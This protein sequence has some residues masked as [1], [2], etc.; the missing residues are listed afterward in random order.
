MLAEEANFLSVAVEGAGITRLRLWVTRR[1]SLPSH[2]KQPFKAALP[3]WE[4][5]I[6]EI[7]AMAGARIN[8]EQQRAMHTVATVV[9]DAV[10]PFE[11]AV[12]TEVF[13]VERPELGVPWYRF[14]VCGVEARPVRTS[15]GLLVTPLYALSHLTEADTVIVPGPRPGIGPIPS[16]LLEALRD[17][18]QRGARLLS[19]CTGAFLLAAAGLLDGRRATTHWLWAAELATRYPKVQ[20]DP[21]VLYID[22]GQILTSAGA[23]ASIDLSLHVVRQDYGAAIAAAV[24]RRMVV[25]PHR[26]GGQAQYIETPLP[27]LDEDDPFGATLTWLL[28]H[29]QEDLS[30]EQ[31]AARAVM[32]PRTFARRFRATLGTT[33]YQWLLQQR[34]I[35]AQRL[36]E[37]TAESVEYIAVCCGFRSA[38]TFRL[39]FEH[40][41]H[42]SPQTYRRAF[43]QEQVGAIVAT[44][45]EKS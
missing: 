10:N 29:L 3:E 18:Y 20:V 26:E 39:H 45:P 14:L 5:C 24:A 27:T 38:A 42:L 1:P 35:L 41:L 13:G 2:E 19:F 16:A 4:R 28:G 33:P 37:T 12:A 32:S 17:A 23:A 44:G 9:Y 25:S 34:I 36:L 30:V 21:Q 15:V 43:H 40:L 6:C 11:L 22:D 8:E 31:L 7:Q